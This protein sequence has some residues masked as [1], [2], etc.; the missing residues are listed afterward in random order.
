MRSGTPPTDLDPEL[1][2]L[3]R[4]GSTLLYSTSGKAVRTHALR[5]AQAAAERGETCIYVSAQH[6]QTLVERADELGFDLADASG[7]GTFRLLPLPSG[8][9]GSAGDEGRTE[10]LADLATVAQR[11]RPAYVIVEEAA[12]LAQFESDDWFDAAFEAMLDRLAEVGS[13]LVLG[14]TDA[15][16]S[17]AY[18]RLQPHM[19]DEVV[20]PESAVPHGDGASYR[21]SPD[22]VVQPSPPTSPALPTGIAYLDLTVAPLPPLPERDAFAHPDRALK[23]GR[24]HYVAADTTFPVE[25]SADERALEHALLGATTVEARSDA[26]GDAPPVALDAD[27]FETV[28]VTATLRSFEGDD[29]EVPDEWV[30]KTAVVPHSP[31]LA[32]VRAFNAALEA[33]DADGAPFLTVAFRMP[34]GHPAGRRFHFVIDALGQLAGSDGV[35]LA[36]EPR[37]RVVLLLPGRGADAAHVVFR[38]VKDHLRASTSEADHLLQTAAAVVVPDGRPYPNA[39]EFLVHVFDA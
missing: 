22:P 19:A 25:G 21:V 27:L 16:E 11:K 32:F 24:G 13:A 33:R 31:R 30:P 28:D 39:T 34:P 18:T 26:A 2:D 36:D 29:T 15:P 1:R 3:A 6:P 4:E 7:M 10:A 9:L 14:L 37:R 8:L 5:L 20:V 12:T 38:A 23:M 17:P 35:L